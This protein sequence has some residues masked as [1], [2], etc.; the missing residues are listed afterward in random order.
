MIKATPVDALPV[1]KPLVVR[2]S[3]LMIAARSHRAKDEIFEAAVAWVEAGRTLVELGTRLLHAGHSY[4]AAQDILNAA[5]CF[6]EAGDHRPAEEQLERFQNLS[7]LKGILRSD[8]FVAE[9]YT[10]VSVWHAKRF[11]ELVKAR[12]ESFSQ[13]QGDVTR[14]DRLKEPW[15]VRT[16]GT[17]PGV[18]ELHFIAAEK[19]WAKRE[20]PLFIQHMH[21]SMRLT[22]CSAPHRVVLIQHLVE[23]RKWKD[24]AAVAKEAVKALPT[25]PYILWFAGCAQTKAVVFGKMPRRLL[26]DAETNLRMSIGCGA[27]QSEEF[28]IG[29]TCSLAVALQTI[30]KIKAADELLSALVRDYACASTDL[31]WRIMNAKANERVEIFR[32][33]SPLYMWNAID[34]AG[35]RPRTLWAA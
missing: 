9:E 35:Y 23:L 10:R 12:R 26:R 22:P 16:L 27:A 31:P 20:F 6:L 18:P 2:T 32:H 19:Y 28:Q 15:L 4:E 25:D 24:A 34:A 3:N 33:E 7:D 21:W 17:L 30:G 13:I 8:T 29:A 11:A 14:F 5:A 1:F